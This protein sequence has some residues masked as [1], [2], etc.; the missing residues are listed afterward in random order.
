MNEIIIYNRLWTRNGNSKRGRARRLESHN[1]SITKT[2]L[3]VVSGSHLDYKLL[4]Q[5]GSRPKE[6]CNIVVLNRLLHKM[7][8]LVKKITD[9]GMN[10]HLSHLL[11]IS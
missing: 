5:W 1:Q 7:L 6:T 10:R 4:R 8:E 2:N 9:G 3:F 11:R